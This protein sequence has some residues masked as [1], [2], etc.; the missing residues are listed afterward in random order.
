MQVISDAC[1]PV[2]SQLDQLSASLAVVMARSQSLALR[3]ACVVLTANLLRSQPA[4]G[5]LP[6]FTP[7]LAQVGHYVRFVEIFRSRIKLQLISASCRTLWPCGSLLRCWTSCLQTTRLR[8]VR[9][10]AV[11]S[12]HSHGWSAAHQCCCQQEL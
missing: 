6:G 7:L 4:G 1:R 5:L 11:A 12:L 10:A 9:L 2:F 3:M 8:G